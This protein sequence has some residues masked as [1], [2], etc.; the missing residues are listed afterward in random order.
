MVVQTQVDVEMAELEVVLASETFAKSPNLAKILRYIGQKCLEGSESV[1]KEYN[2]AVEALGRS[3]DFDPKEDSIV[4]VE[5]HRLREKLKHYYEIEGADHLIIIGLRAGSYIPQ[6]VRRHEISGNSPNQPAIEASPQTAAG[7]EK[8]VRLAQFIA[9]PVPSAQPDLALKSESPA[10][11]PHGFRRLYTLGS[12]AAGAILIAI[13]AAKTGYLPRARTASAKTAVPVVDARSGAFSIITG[14]DV[15]II[16]GYSKR[17]YLDRQGN[18]WGPDRYY[19]GGTTRVEPH[20]FIARAADNTLF[21]T[22]RQGEFSYD[23]PLKPGPHELRLYFVEREY[24][25][26]TT[27]GGGEISRLF[28]VDLNGNRLLTDFDIFS[29]ANGTNVADERVFK[30]IAP[31]SDGQLHLKFTEGINYPLLNAV[32]VVPGL[33]GKML[34]VRIVAQEHSYTDEEGRLWSPD[35]Y[36]SSGRLATNVPPIDGTSDPGLYSSYRFGHF[37]YAIPVAEGSYAVT[38]YFAETYFGAKNPGK[39]GEGARL[40][41]VYCNG[42]ALLR[43]FDIL[44]EAG[45][46]NRALKKT[47]HGLQPN[48]MGKLVLSFVP[49]KNYASIRAI[50]VVDESK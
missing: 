49:V 19:T 42:A 12:I 5:V 35:R 10:V 7:G 37:D 43:N 16:S 38:L 8:A 46:E 32:E 24:G 3:P 2:I 1:L 23:I 17:D 15:R 22:A 27:R 31:A 40:F 28:H 47:F 50:E 41:D 9:L 33:R 30:D 44:Q 36:F 34:P 21:E 45:A 13:L 6:F 39:V 14:D 29:D 48:A 11:K 18:T 4:R 26:G 20:V 25:P